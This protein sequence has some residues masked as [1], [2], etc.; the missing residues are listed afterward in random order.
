MVPKR[1]V[2]G[3]GKVIAGTELATFSSLYLQ[4]TALF[5]SLPTRAI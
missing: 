4:A 2:E 3:S 5:R 1:S